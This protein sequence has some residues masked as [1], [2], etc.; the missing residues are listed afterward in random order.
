MLKKIISLV[1]MCVA[2]AQVV[3][4]QP[5]EGLTYYLPQTVVKVRLLIQHQKFVPGRLA[6]YGQKYLRKQCGM[7]A[8]NT[9]RVCGASMY[10]TALPDTSRRYTVNLD[11]K[12][13]IFNVECDNNGV[14]MAVNDQGKKPSVPARFK[15]A[16]QQPALNPD[17]F[18]TADMLAAGSNSKLAELVAQEI[19]DIRDAR[20]QINRG[21]SDQMPKDGEQL[22]LMLQGLDQQETALMQLFTGV[23]TIDTTETEV[24]FVPQK[25]K[26]R[27]LLFRLSKWLGLVDSDDMAGA[28]YYMNVE[29]LNDVAMPELSQTDKKKDKEEPALVVAIPA[30]IRL[31]LTDEES[32]PIDTEEMY[33]AQFG[34]VYGISQELFSKKQVAHIRLNPITGVVEYLD[35]EP[36]K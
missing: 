30:K 31:T 1:L 27:V 3:A 20:N 15:P 12:K 29:Q 32:K 9:Y 2:T 4:Q 25:G 26:N 24:T 18:M 14:L 33:A 23:T 19:F 28:P 35:V 21:E 13:V 16:H 5:V 22:R 7:E 34:D 6:V 17:N 36:L 8:E 11:R 10:A